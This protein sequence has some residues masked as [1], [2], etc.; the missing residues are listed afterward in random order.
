MSSFAQIKVIAAR[1]QGTMLQDA[2]GAFA[3]VVMLFVGL[4]LPSFF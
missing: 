1:A 3:L 4:Y 2:L